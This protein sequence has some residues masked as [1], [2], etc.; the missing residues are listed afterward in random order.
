MKKTTLPKADLTGILIFSLL[1]GISSCQKM[2][3]DRVIKI[4]TGEVVRVG[5]TQARIQGVIA[6]QG[7]IFIYEHGHCWSTGSQPVTSDARTRLGSVENETE[8][9][10]HLTGLL[11]N[12]TYYIRA[13]ASNED[14]TVYG[15]IREI[16][17]FSVEDYDGNGYHT[18]IIGTQVWMQENMKATRYS[19]G[20]VIDSALAYNNDEDIAEEYGRMYYWIAA[21]H[22]S[23]IE[24]AQGICPDGWHVPSAPEYQSLLDYLG[25]SV[26]AH[27]KI[28]EGGTAHWNPPNENATNESG[29]T[30]LPGG[31]CVDN[32]FGSLKDWCNLWTSS[33][34]DDDR[35]ASKLYM[36]E[37]EYCHINYGSPSPGFEKYNKKRGAFFSVRCIED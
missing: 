19:D 20:S 31:D 26:T 32:N 4:H 33:D 37:V 10:S 36:D 17:T 35:Y 21:M 2:D 3:F 5:A 12:K 22:G 18:V 30:A 29:F 34:M 24:E 7:D 15:E 1:I 28:M 11:P 27:W 13:Y 23:T 8:F 6:D 9:E 14:T 16:T 25:G